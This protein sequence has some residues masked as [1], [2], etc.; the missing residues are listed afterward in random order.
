MPNVQPEDLPIRP[1]AQP[2]PMGPVCT[3]GNCVEVTPIDGGVV[4]TSTLGADKGRVEY[5]HGEWAQ[6]VGDVK[7]GRVDHTV[8]VGVPI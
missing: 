2:W 3:G 8:S 1:A 6:F 5:T 4:L 7:A